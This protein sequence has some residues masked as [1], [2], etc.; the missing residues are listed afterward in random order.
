MSIEKVIHYMET[1]KAIYQLLKHCPYVILKKWTIEKFESASI[2]RSQG[3]IYNHFS[4]IVE[5]TADIYV[6]AENGK[7]YVQSRYYPGGMIGEI[8]IFN[9][10]PF[11]S[12]VEALTEVTIITLSREHFIQWLQLD[13]NFNQQFIQKSMELSYSIT[14][15][16][17]VSKLYSLNDLICQHLIEKIPIGKK[18]PEGITITIDKHFLSEQFAVTQRSINRV[19]ATLKEKNIID[20]QHQFIIIKDVDYL[21]KER[22]K[23]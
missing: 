23:N 5:G 14:K 20:F 12:N 4:L 16:D 11:I 2:I 9:S 17:E 10:V 22:L 19:L 7:K 3:E 6:V 15:R 18:Q 8:E 1:N 13:Q 21:L